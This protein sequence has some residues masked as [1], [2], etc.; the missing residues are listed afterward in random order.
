MFEESTTVVIAAE[1]MLREWRYMA[2]SLETYLDLVRNLKASL[3]NNLREA[4]GLLSHE[5]GVAQW[6]PAV[7]GV[8]AVPDLGRRVAPHPCVGGP[9]V[10]QTGG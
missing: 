6:D 4:R 10:H 5:D 1:M 2:H 7:P 3:K 8:G 9:D